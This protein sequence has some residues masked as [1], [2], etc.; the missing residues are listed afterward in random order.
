MA[1]SVALPRQRLS[2]FAKFFLLFNS[3]LHIHSSFTADLHSAALNRGKNYREYRA[4]CLPNDNI[5]RLHLLHHRP[6]IG[7]G[8]FGVK[9]TTLGS[10]SHFYDSR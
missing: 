3:D 1:V 10:I 5:F 6:L 4:L 7:N 2:D 8:T 9:L